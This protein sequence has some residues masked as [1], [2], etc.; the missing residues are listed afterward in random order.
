MP[1]PLCRR[2]PFPYGRTYENRTRQTGVRFSAC[3]FVQVKPPGPTSDGCGIEATSSRIELSVVQ[4][5]LYSPPVFVLS[6]IIFCGKLVKT[7][8]L[9]NTRAEKFGSA[10]ALST[11]TG[12]LRSAAG[13]PAESSQFFGRPPVAPEADVA[14]V[15]TPRRP[16]APVAGGRA[17]STRA[18]PARDVYVNRQP[19]RLQVSGL[20]GVVVGPGARGEY[21]GDLFRLGRLHVS[22]QELLDEVLDLPDGLAAHVGQD[23]GAVLGLLRLF[24]RD[25]YGGSRVLPLMA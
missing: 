7:F 4:Y 16:D 23:Q 12:L 2:V 3:T 11:T 22:H 24:C 10:Q 6:G 13:N 21:A 9:Q 1:S 15:C 14:R 18:R 17:A 20:Q 25:D 5:L 8:A 19:Q